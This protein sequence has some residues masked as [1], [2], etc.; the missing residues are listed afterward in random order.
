M[1]ARCLRTATSLLVCFCAGTLLAQGIILGYLWSAWQ[2]DRQ[3]LLQMLAVAR[4]ADVPTDHEQ[5]SDRDEIPPEQPSYQDWIDKR[6]ALF[7]DL[8][9][10]E[11][12][13][14]NALE[15]LRFQQQELVE[16]QETHRRLKQQFEAGLAA[17]KQSAEAE[18]R[19]TVGRI[20]ETI[21][22]KQAKE[23]ILEMLD[24]EEIDEVVILLSEMSDSKRAKILG[25]FKTEEENE[26][27]GEV[28]RL[29]RQ[30]EPESGIADDVIGQVQRGQRAGAY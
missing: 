29:I 13:L 12:A 16:D 14:N 27:I 6:A 15:Q 28:L 19:E 17:L 8:E 18:G 25:E 7:R 1:I 5:P 11:L 24:N 22:P 26:K 23:Q 21:K 2:L 3:K 10:R 4:G 30:G 20:L 9:L